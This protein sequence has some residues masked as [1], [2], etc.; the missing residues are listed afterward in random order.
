M[1]LSNMPIDKKNHEKEPILYKKEIKK[2]LKNNDFLGINN[3]K[4]E[5]NIFFP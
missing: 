1:K 3:V 5:L 4:K 2:T